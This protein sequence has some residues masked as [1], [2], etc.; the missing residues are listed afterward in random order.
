MSEE[1]QKQVSTLKKKSIYLEGE[2]SFNLKTRAFNQTK[3]TSEIFGDCNQKFPLL[4]RLCAEKHYI[5]NKE[6]DNIV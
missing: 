4:D 3:W 5:D 2:S 1:H 6:R